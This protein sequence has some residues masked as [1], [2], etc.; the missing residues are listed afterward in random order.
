MENFMKRNNFK[1][2]FVSTCYNILWFNLTRDGIFNH[3]Y[4]IQFFFQNKN[5]LL[6]AGE[7]R[8]QNGMF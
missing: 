4:S 1:F 3:E 5:I 2:H 6:I 8:E 7:A